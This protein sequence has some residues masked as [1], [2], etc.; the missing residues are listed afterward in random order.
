MNTQPATRGER[1]NNPCNL[2][3]FGI[4]WDGLDAPRH[5]DGGY[6]RFVSPAAGIRA[7]ARDLNSKWRR[8][9]TT[10]RQIIGVFAPPSE[11]ATDAYIRDVAARLGVGP[12]E[13]LDLGAVAVLQTF[14]TAVIC[15]ENGRCS[16][17]SDLIA[18]ATA[19]A[20]AR[21]R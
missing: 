13:P 1:N 7:G 15:H 16:Y 3:D 20:L 12:D 8:G 9:L 2:R 21:E 17:A 4:D 5:D 14:V 11:N 19:P 18:A 6:C 10:V